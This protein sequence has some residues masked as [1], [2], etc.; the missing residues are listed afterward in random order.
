MVYLEYARATPL[1]DLVRKHPNQGEK[2]MFWEAGS[3]EIVREQKRS[4]QKTKDNVYS[5]RRK[6][7]FLFILSTV[8]T[9]QVFNISTDI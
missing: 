8:P 1:G 2:K 6:Q 9:C 5:Q 4:F 7:K 3:I